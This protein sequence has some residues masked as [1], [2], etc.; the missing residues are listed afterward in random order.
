MRQSMPANR[1]SKS[2]T[3]SCPYCLWLVSGLVACIA[4]PGL[5]S[6]M[7]PIGPTWLVL[8]VV[9]FLSAVLRRVIMTDRPPARRPL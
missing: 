7:T 6:G 8:L 5:G 9:P 2:A 4:W 1:H 3:V